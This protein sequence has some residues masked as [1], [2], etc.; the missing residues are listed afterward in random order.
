MVVP[1]CFQSRISFFIAFFNFLFTK[2]DLII[3]GTN[4][5]HRVYHPRCRVETRNALHPVAYDRAPFA[6]ESDNEYD[7]RP[8]TWNRGES[9]RHRRRL[10]WNQLDN[11]G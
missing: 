2:P 9:S 4:H 10:K 6:A 7:T 5:A 3:D 11:K 8:H 1:I